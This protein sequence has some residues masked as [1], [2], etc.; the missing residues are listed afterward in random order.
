MRLLSCAYQTYVAF[1]YLYDVAAGTDLLWF[2]FST[3]VPYV[4]IPFVYYSVWRFV[5][6]SETTFSIFLFSY[7]LL[8][9]FAFSKFLHPAL[10]V[11]VFAWTMLCLC[12]QLPKTF[13]WLDK[14]FWVKGAELKTKVSKELLFTYSFQMQRWE[15]NEKREVT[16]TAWK[17]YHRERGHAEALK[18]LEKLERR[19]CDHCGVQGPTTGPR[20]RPCAKC[21]K[22]TYC[23][24]LCQRSDWDLG[25]HKDVC[26]MLA[27]E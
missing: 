18:V 12:F 24:K 14:T 21:R 10:G 20:F 22:R 4:G 2:C 11:A 5:Y 3:R 15:T 25:R 9:A 26:A 1:P 23:C 13:Q 27:C 7:S 17:A 6:V 16:R 8:Q 19:T